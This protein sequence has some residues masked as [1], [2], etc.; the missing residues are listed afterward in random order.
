MRSLLILGRG[1]ARAV[2]TLSDGRQQIVAVFTAGDMLN[3]VELP[4]EQS[5]TSVYALTAATV[6]P[7][8]I[9]DLYLLI[10]DRPAIG[11]ALWLETAAQAAIKREWIVGL[12]RRNAQTR[13]AHFLCEVSYRLHLSYGDDFDAFEFPMTQSELADALGLTTVHVNRVLQTLRS[14]GLIEL[15]R[16]QLMI[17]NKARLYEIAGFDPRYLRDKKPAY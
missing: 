15:G 9:S 6:V 1:M 11:R 10:A 5:L 8:P 13:L 14:Q 4:L 3:L 2:R 16:T 17:R 7:I 12:G